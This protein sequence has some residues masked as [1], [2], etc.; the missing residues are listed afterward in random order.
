METGCGVSTLTT[1]M[2]GWTCVSCSRI[3]MSRRMRATLK[4]MRIPPTE[5]R[6]ALIDF[7]LEPKF[8]VPP[9]VSVRVTIKGLVHLGFCYT[10]SEYTIRKIIE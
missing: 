1:S 3:C 5:N 7:S 4:P 10:Q 8:K 6:T 9:R 2:L